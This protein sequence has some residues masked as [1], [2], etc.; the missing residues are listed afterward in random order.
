MESDTHG[1]IIGI[2]N[3]LL[4][5]QLPVQPNAQ[6]ISIHNASPIRGVNNE[7]TVQESS[8]E[9]GNKKDRLEMEEDRLQKQRLIEVM[10]QE[11]ER[12]APSLFSNLETMFPLQI[13]AEVSIPSDT[14]HKIQAKIVSTLPN[15]IVFDR[16]NGLNI[17]EK[18]IIRL[19]SHDT[20]LKETA[21]VEREYDVQTV[22]WERALHPRAGDLNI[23]TGSMTVTFEVQQEGGKSVEV[24]DEFPYLANSP[25]IHKVE[26]SY[27]ID[28]EVKAFTPKG[29]V[30]KSV[31]LYKLDANGTVDSHPPY[32]T[33]TIDEKMIQEVNKSNAELQTESKRIASLDEMMAYLDQLN[34]REYLDIRPLIRN[35]RNYND[36]TRSLLLK[37]IN[38]KIAEAGSVS[39]D[40]IP[41][42]AWYLQQRSSS[43]RVVKAVEVIS[44]PFTTMFAQT[45]Y[46]KNE[47]III[48]QLSQHSALRSTGETWI[49]TDQYFY[50]TTQEIRKQLYERCIESIRSQ[51]HSIETNVSYTYAGSPD[52]VINPEKLKVIYERAL[53]LVL[54]ECPLKSPHEFAEG[55]KQ[56]VDTFLNEYSS[57]YMVYRLLQKFSLPPEF[58]GDSETINRIVY[59]LEHAFS[60]TDITKVPPIIISTDTPDHALYR[61]ISTFTNDKRKYPDIAMVVQKLMKAL[62]EGPRKQF[63]VDET[64]NIYDEIA[65]LK[66]KYAMAQSTPMSYDERVRRL[67]NTD[68]IY[69][70]QDPNG[71]AELYTYDQFGNKVEIHFEPSMMS[72]GRLGFQRYGNI[73]P[74][75]IGI[76]ER[77]YANNTFVFSRPTMPEVKVESSN[78]TYKTPPSRPN[79]DAQKME[80]ASG[81][82]QILTE[83]T[84]LNYAAEKKTLDWDT[85]RTLVIDDVSFTQLRANIRKAV[86]TAGGTNYSY[87]IKEELQKYR[88]QIF[89]ARMLYKEAAEVNAQATSLFN[90][91]EDMRGYMDYVV[92]GLYQLIIKGK[93][94]PTDEEL[95]NVVSHS[96]DDYI[97]SL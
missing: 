3:K 62:E 85:L 68:T 2:Q 8:Q 96:I 92:M 74:D 77:A 59:S 47:K 83:G 9:Q 7:L 95:R 39:D 37:D 13:G 94:F 28:Q 48:E 12:Q 71:K 32:G 73:D 57:I 81:T 69:A 84:L 80:A 14:N 64:K 20:T 40:S 46:D 16:N 51:I 22:G 89:T 6:L 5:Y 88:A 49:S 36:P 1:S 79:P 50:T 18:Q 19:S 42:T 44:L 60:K 72:N 17:R 11:F 34:L 58:R 15:E 66:K 75:S 86:Q 35:I 55:R 38:V 90:T 70:Q 4:E 93:T 53:E 45:K 97:N 56:V 63:V 91:P 76:I 27:Q 30:E 31:I 29:W 33:Y 26:G 52:T 10:Q 23:K 41:G 82:V 61:L 21:V 24:K 78:T 54:E 87:T 65:D 43:V 25:Q 67:Q